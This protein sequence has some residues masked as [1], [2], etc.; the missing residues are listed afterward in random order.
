MRR[1]TSRIA[2]LATLIAALGLGASPA[3][4]QQVTCIGYV[5]EVSVGNVVVPEGET[6][7]LD[8][9]DVR[10]NVTVERDAT[11]EAQAA[12]I[13]GNLQA[14]GAERVQIA[15][16]SQVR[17]NIQIRRGWAISV[18]DSRIGGNLQLDRNRGDLRVG[19]NAVGGNLQ[20]LGNHGGLAITRNRIGGNLQCEGNRPAPR[21]RDNRVRGNQGGQCDGYR[22]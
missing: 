14:D 19:R 12:R 7:V 11:L 9:T 2:L 3:R 1:I 20:A 15:N 21:V 4:A 13:A 6:C 22:G 8:G 16:G 18:I 10:G 5:D 17:G